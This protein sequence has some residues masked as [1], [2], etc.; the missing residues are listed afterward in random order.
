VLCHTRCRSLG[1]LAG[2]RRVLEASLPLS[3]P[4]PALAP[5]SPPMLRSGRRA[6][7]AG[8]KQPTTRPALHT[9][10]TARAVTAPRLRQGRG[11]PATPPARGAHQTRR[12]WCARPPDPPPHPKPARPPPVPESRSPPPRHQLHR[13]LVACSPLLTP[14]TAVRQPPRLLEAR[15]RCT[16]SHCG[17]HYTGTRTDDIASPCIRVH[18][19]IIIRSLCRNK[20]AATPFPPCS[21]P[22]PPAPMWAGIA[23]GLLPP[24]TKPVQWCSAVVV[25]SQQSYAVMLVTRRVMRARAS[26]VC[27]CA[28]VV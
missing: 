14:R 23:R 16:R 3:L 18:S 15:P 24:T 22:P 13:P 10:M 28:R 26:R 1:H 25:S 7:G 8:V 19:L 11:T 12:R 6:V 27:A 20:S 21:C 9:A 17:S 5:T 2:G 4:P